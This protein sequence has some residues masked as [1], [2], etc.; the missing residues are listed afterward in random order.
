MSS[1][2]TEPNKKIPIITTNTGIRIVMLPNER[3]GQDEVWACA[4]DFC[5]SINHKEPLL[6]IQQYVD[7]TEVKVYPTDTPEQVLAFLSG[8]GC[9]Q[10]YK[11]TQ[12]SQQVK[13]LLNVSIERIRTTKDQ[14]GTVWFSTLDACKALGFTNPTAT[15]KLHVSPQNISRV[16]FTDAN[17]GRRQWLTATNSEGYEEL[18]QAQLHKRGSRPVGAEKVIP[19]EDE[20]TVISAPTKQAPKSH[21][22][23]PVYTRRT[24]WERRLLNGHVAIHF[25]YGSN[26]VL[27]GTKGY[28]TYE[29]ITI[30]QDVATDAHTVFN[31]LGYLMGYKN[32]W[33]IAFQHCTEVKMVPVRYQLTLDMLMSDFIQSIRRTGRKKDGH[34]YVGLDVWTENPAFEF[35]LL[36]WFESFYY[37]EDSTNTLSSK[38]C[39]L[40]KSWADKVLQGLC[41]L[42]E[43]GVLQP[44]KV[45]REPEVQEELRRILEGEHLIPKGQSID[46]VYTGEFSDPYIYRFRFAPCWIQAI[47]SETLPYPVGIPPIL[48]R[49]P[50]GGRNYGYKYTCN[51]LLCTE[52]YRSTRKQQVSQDKV[53]NLSLKQY[54]LLTGIPLYSNWASYS[55]L[56]HNSNKREHYANSMIKNT[57]EAYDL[58]TLANLTWD[59]KGRRGRYST[60]S[61]KA[62]LA[63]KPLY[64]LS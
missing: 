64:L 26:W 11:H 51:R 16:I 58:F 6:T 15:L 29:E 45:K 5:Q 42:M 33:S 19:I 41:Y 40:F 27:K 10:L 54:C 36:E 30:H 8:K 2:Y 28:K 3:T 9:E 39:M 46:E 50:Y 14:S 35:N 38:P 59:D 48:G 25:T 63:I 20:S 1:I 43:T 47:Q 17:T 7:S 18:R 32:D 44:V 55:N 56:V 60:P 37:S 49:I 24:N 23:L 34:F 4:V 12:Q 61:D 52:L 21:H 62:R 31:H 22:W 57:I 53:W 13:A